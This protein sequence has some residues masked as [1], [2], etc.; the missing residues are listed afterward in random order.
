M[1]VVLYSYGSI[2]IEVR[3]VDDITIKTVVEPGIADVPDNFVLHQNYPNPF[4]P[5]TTIR[6]DLAKTTDVK[7]T[8]YDISGRR[9]QEL[10]NSSMNAGSY[11]LRWNAGHLSSGMYLYR[12][13][14]PEFTATNKLLLLK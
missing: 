7:L 12:I 9:I 14:T 6:L 11:D 5:I 10:V 1:G 4:N 13:E 8:I 3:K 2:K